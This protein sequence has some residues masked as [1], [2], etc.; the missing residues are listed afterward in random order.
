MSSLYPPAAV[1][2]ESQG[3]GFF[4]SSLV[5]ASADNLNLFYNEST[6]WP[7]HCF[8]FQLPALTQHISSTSST[9]SDSFPEKPNKY[10]PSKPLC[11]ENQFTKGEQES[12]KFNSHLRLFCVVLHVLLVLTVL[13]PE[14]VDF[15]ILGQ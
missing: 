5:F 4:S 1:L 11:Q 3:R 9:T 15:P 13:S 14:A 12:C 7:S 8:S 6:V 10:L 2:C